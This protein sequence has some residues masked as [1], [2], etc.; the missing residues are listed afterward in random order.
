VNR[1]D[2]VEKWFEIPIL[3]AALAVIPTVLIQA[4]SLGEPWQTLANVLN[5]LTWSV[6]VIELAAMLVLQ[7]DRWRWLLR[8]PLELAIVVL[9]PPFLPRTLHLIRA[10]PLLRLLRVFRLG[11]AARRTFSI[12]GLRYAALMALITVLGGGAAFTAVEKGHNPAVTSIW[13][14]AWFALVTITTVGYGDIAPT[15][16]GGRLIASVVMLVGI[17]FL[18]VL[19]GAIAER[20]IHGRSTADRLREHEE[21]I[22][23]ELRR[24]EERIP[25]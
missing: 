24:L 6:F 13:D 22:L 1:A 7:P 4:S 20:F 11:P 9:S 5:W 10:L 18:A 3:L 16:D 17:G 23:N 14:G 2:R 19:T 12:E 15:T 8:H 21:R 25:G